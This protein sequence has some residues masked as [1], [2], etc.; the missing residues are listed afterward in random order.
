MKPRVKESEHR[1][2]FRDLSV[3]TY[4]TQKGPIYSGLSTFRLVS[5]YPRCS[6]PEV[7]MMLPRLERSKGSKVD[8]P[9]AQGPAFRTRGVHA[10][11]TFFSPPQVEVNT[12]IQFTTVPSVFFLLFCIST[13]IYQFRDGSTGAFQYEAHETC[14][15]PRHAL[16]AINP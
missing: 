10:L 1:N 7:F 12:K 6:G 16:R 13:K 14:I 4:Q 2:F 8:R 5:P 11:V 9:R 3:S 15:A